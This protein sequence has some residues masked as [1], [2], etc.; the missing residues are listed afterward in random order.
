[1]A[2]CWHA[3]LLLVLAAAVARANVTIGWNTRSASAPKQPANVSQIQ[4]ALVLDVH[5]TRVHVRMNDGTT[6]SLVATPKQAVELARRVGRHVQ[7]RVS[8]AAPNSAP[9]TP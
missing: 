5:G 8:G 1:M 2:R 9:L 7:F 4:K 6:R 3:A